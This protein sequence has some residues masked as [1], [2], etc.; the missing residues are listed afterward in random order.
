MHMPHQVQAL[1]KTSNMCCSSLLVSATSAKSFA[2]NTAC[3]QVIRKSSSVPIDQK[4]FSANGVV[5]E[6]TS[7]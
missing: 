4:E 6:Q 3:M 2:S 1:S 7:S 5:N